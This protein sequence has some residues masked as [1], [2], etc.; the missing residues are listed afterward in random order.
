MAT[1]QIWEEAFKAGF[2]AGYANGLVGPL[3]Q[4]Q[5]DGNAE[6]EYRIWL[7]ENESILHII[8]AGTFPKK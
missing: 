8:D 4:S 2:K 3:T 7:K 1:K 5:Q 6:A